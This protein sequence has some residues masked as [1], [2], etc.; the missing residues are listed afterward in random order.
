MLQDVILILT[1]K[2]N[3]KRTFIDLNK[4][5]DSYISKI[6]LANK[7]ELSIVKTESLRHSVFYQGGLTMSSD[8][9]LIRHKDFEAYL[10]R[11]A[12]DWVL[13]DDLICVKE[14]AS[15]LVDV[16][17]FNSKP[18]CV[19]ELKMLIDNKLWYFDKERLPT[20]EGNCP[21]DSDEILSWDKKNILTGTGENNSAIMSRNQWGEMCNQ[22]KNWFT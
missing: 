1:A 15:Y 17:I 11:D 13:N 10:W 4:V 9:I 8:T 20:F 12:D 5:F 19:V 14:I 3:V 22:E 21:E 6:P 18:E 16:S 7:F 2:K